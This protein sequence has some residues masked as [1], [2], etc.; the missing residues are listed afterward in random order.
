VTETS[1]NKIYFDKT[2][3]VRIASKDEVCKSHLELHLYPTAETIAMKAGP[4]TQPL[5]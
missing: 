3:Q 5:M 2:K 1:K 4:S